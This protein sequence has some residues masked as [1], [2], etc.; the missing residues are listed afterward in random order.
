[1]ASSS[2]ELP[3]KHFYFAFILKRATA[4]SQS[5]SENST[6]INRSKKWSIQAVVSPLKVP[7][8]DK[9]RQWQRLF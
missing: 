9:N 1:M 8:F 7:V 3:K 6:V 2:E 5:T 4:S